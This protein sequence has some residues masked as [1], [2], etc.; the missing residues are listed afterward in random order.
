MQQ[1]LKK[2]RSPHE[3][4][5]DLVV[6]TRRRI[7]VGDFDSK[8]SIPSDSPQITITDSSNPQQTNPAD[9][10]STINSAIHDSVAQTSQ[11]DPE[12]DALIERAIRASLA[13]LSTGATDRSGGTAGED[14]NDEEALY[15][16]MEASLATAQDHRARYGGTNV[17]EG[18]AEL[19]AA[20]AASLAE[21]SRRQ[22]GGDDHDEDVRKALQASQN[23]H[24][25]QDEEEM[26]QAVKES[27]R[28]AEEEKKKAEDEERIVLE[29]VK[30]Q[31]LLEE[32]QRRKG[33]KGKARDDEGDDE[34]LERALRVSLGKEGEHGQGSSK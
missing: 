3:H 32:E 27:Q 12:Q 22:A 14:L 1:N 21:R 15:R 34:E 30:K 6:D 13:E 8:K 11:G 24:S 16:A 26:S 33:G 31:S 18:D 5:Q 17:E 9:P 29:Y 19:E 23:E 4:L 7:E 2:K 20:L 10:S 25:G 28:L